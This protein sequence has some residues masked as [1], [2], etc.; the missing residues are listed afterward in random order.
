MTRERQRRGA[1]G[2]G[3]DMQSKKR[4]GALRPTEMK[5]AERSEDRVVTRKPAAMPGNTR[6]C[7]RRTTR[8]S[9]RKDDGD[10]AVT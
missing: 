3:V 7:D 9:A 1:T 6:N 4:R 8:S 5:L 10:R 2:E